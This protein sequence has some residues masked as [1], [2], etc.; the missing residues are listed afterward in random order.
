MKNVHGSFY[1]PFNEVG[2]VTHMLKGV[3]M[4]KK[5]AAIAIGNVI[6]YTVVLTGTLVFQGELF[7][8]SMHSMEKMFND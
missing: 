4:L 2:K 8:L 7:K 6:A 3:I 1:T 5:I